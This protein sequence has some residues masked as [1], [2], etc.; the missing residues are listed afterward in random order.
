MDSSLPVGIHR[1]FVVVTRFEKMKRRL[2]VC[3]GC[4]KPI[5]LRGGYSYKALPRGRGKMMGGQFLACSRNWMS[6]PILSEAVTMFETQ[7][8][9]L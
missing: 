5:L 7:D 8:I 2:F 4:P 1:Q 6:E 3:Q 9:D